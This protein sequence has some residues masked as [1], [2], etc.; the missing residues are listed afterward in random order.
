MKSQI[1][2]AA[3]G[4]GERLGNITINTPK[5]MIL[6]HGQPII[7]Y[8]I[9]S[10]KN[11][12]ID[13]IVVGLDNGKENFK[14]Y[15]YNL[16][17][18]VETDCVE[19]L[20]KVFLRSA[21]ERNPD[22][23]IGVNGDTIYY[24]ESISRV[25]KMLNANSDAA[26][27]LLLTKV[28]RPTFTSS[29]IYWR[30]RVENGI[31]M[32]M[33]EVAGHKITTEYV[34]AIFRTAALKELSNNFTDDF[35]NYSLLPFSCYSFGWDYLLRLLLW[36]KF[37]IAGLI[38]DDLSLN[39]NHPRDLVEGK[40]LFNNPGYFRWAR[41][42][43]D[44]FIEPIHQEKT[45]LLIK[46]TAIK[47]NLVSV[48]KSELD[49]FGLKIISEITHQFDKQMAINWYQ[50]HQNKSWFSEAVKLLTIGNSISLIVK[51][52]GAFYKALCWKKAIRK[53]FAITKTDNLVHATFSRCSFEAELQREMLILG[54]K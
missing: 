45:L 48:I 19:P 27:V 38:S 41:M 53:R 26:A 40:F 9:D 29:W 28:V 22:V 36:R 16:G 42:I 54:L 10:A 43:P 52:R 21:K 20:T 33:D 49:K 12:G 31:V 51:G 25:I 46:P 5:S 1:F 7:N 15:L 39:V 34:M 23:I 37:K 3:G 32:A 2:I 14:K 44:G 18:E 50:E 24:S 8:V 30:H 13:Q 11:A 4:K 17:V 47:L 6:F 35:Q